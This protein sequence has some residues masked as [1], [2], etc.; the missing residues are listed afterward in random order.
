M[1]WYKARGLNRF[2]RGMGCQ[3]AG[4]TSVLWYRFGLARF[5]LGYATPERRVCLFLRVLCSCCFPAPL[6]AHLFGVFD[7]FIERRGGALGFWV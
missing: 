2:A 3:M 4:H 1:W 5:V 7:G 6:T